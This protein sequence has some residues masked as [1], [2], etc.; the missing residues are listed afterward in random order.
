[1]RKASLSVLS[2][3]W[4]GAKSVVPSEREKGVEKE[5]Y[6]RGWPFSKECWCCELVAEV[7]WLDM[8]LEMDFICYKIL[9]DFMALL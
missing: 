1:M 9:S 6:L 5:A 4:H 3:T 7:S 8:R 2:R